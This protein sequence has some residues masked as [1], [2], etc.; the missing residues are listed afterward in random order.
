MY[1]LE[2]CQIFF[3]D[4][5]TSFAL[6]QPIQVL[7][8]NFHGTVCHSSTNALSAAEVDLNALSS[9]SCGGTSS[10]S[11]GSSGSPPVGNRLSGIDFFF[12]RRRPRSTQVN[13]IKSCYIYHTCFDFFRPSLITIGHHYNECARRMTDMPVDQRL[14]IQD[15]LFCYRICK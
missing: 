15:S 13:K 5:W 2:P 12:D 14:G 4:F 10:L 6:R 9:L 3:R 8:A 11:S 7:G 1:W